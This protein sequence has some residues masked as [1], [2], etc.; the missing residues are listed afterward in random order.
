MIDVYVDTQGW[1]ALR[2]RTDAHHTEASRLWDSLRGAEA[3]FVTSQPVL[4]E[5]YTLLTRRGTH[6]DAVRFGEAVRR[7]ADLEVVYVD[8][9]LEAAAW[10]LSMRYDDKAFSFVDCISFAIMQQRGILQAL[11]N[12]HHFEQAGFQA[13]LRPGQE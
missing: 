2:I 8:A 10:R 6:A 11:T 13:L 5:T 12:D 1:A 4:G 7:S 3:R 9:T